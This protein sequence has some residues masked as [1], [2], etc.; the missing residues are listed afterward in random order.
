MTIQVP[1]AKADLA[2]EFANT[3]YWR[4][5]ETHSETLNSPDDLLKWCADAKIP[6][7]AIEGLRLWWQQHPRKA[8]QA[9]G[10][11]LELREAI[12]RI[13]RSIAEE[14]DPAAAD[15][16]VLNNALSEAPS[17]AHLVRANGGYAWALP[18]LEPEIT[19]LLA[20]VIW[21]AG[22]LL[23]EPA[24][25]KVRRCANDE[26]VWLFLDD[27]KSGTRRWCDMKSC[28]NRAK[29]HRHYAKMKKQAKKK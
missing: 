14:A 1:A 12:Y 9:L 24:R 2:L 3:R 18:D 8:D 22:D 16:D 4:G 26:C 11:A 6:A 28:G 15:L 5:R 21:A 29:A 7:A 20:P 23:I 25:V 10:A 13:F 19:A 27:S 17:R